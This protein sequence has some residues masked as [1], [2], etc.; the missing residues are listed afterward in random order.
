MRARAAEGPPSPGPA[1]ALPILRASVPPRAGRPA[2]S[3]RP[4]RPRGRSPSAA[5]VPAEHVGK[6][7]AEGRRRG[8]SGWQLGP[9]GPPFLVAPLGG[10]WGNT[11]PGRSGKGRRK[12]AL[13][14][15]LPGT[16]LPGTEAPEGRPLAADL[17]G[18][19]PASR[20]RVWP[21]GWGRT[22]ASTFWFSSESYTE[23]TRRPS[24][25]SQGSFVFLVSEN[26]PLVAQTL[27][28]PPHWSA[29]PAN[30]S[31][32]LLGGSFT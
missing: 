8:G 25:R 19:R 11:R 4:L 7:S 6:D 13:P 3:P 18:G 2:R 17:P 20:P 9:L 28:Y 29:V 5:R 15:P 14:R 23:R 12:T 22:V 31:S 24:H 32:R 26:E 27:P 1:R 16:G 21:L 30:P 10:G